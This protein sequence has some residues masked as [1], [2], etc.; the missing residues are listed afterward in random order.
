MDERKSIPPKE[1]EKAKEKQLEQQLSKFK[2]ADKEVNKIKYEEYDEDEDY[3]V[4]DLE[5]SGEQDIYQRFS[6]LSRKRISQEIMNHIEENA[7]Y[8]PLYKPLLINITLPNQLIEPDLL[9]TI[10][11]LVEKSLIKRIND[12]TIQIRQIRVISTLMVLFGLVAMTVA[13]F[14]SEKYLNVFMLQEIFTIASWVFIW[15]SVEGF[16]FDQRKA[17]LQKY[18]LLQIYSADYQSKL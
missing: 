17:S 1:L 15:K 5:L 16:A 11:L 9:K 13:I 4:I 6:M 8:I 10:E 14:L 12:L 7:R 3:A 18:K 2:E